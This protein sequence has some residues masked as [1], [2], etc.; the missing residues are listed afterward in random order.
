MA[1]LIFWLLAT[2]HFA[3]AQVTPIPPF[4]GDHSETWEEFGTGLLG[5][6]VP[7]LGGFATIS[8][9][10]LTTGKSFIM[11]TVVAKPS[12]GDTLMY[13]DRVAGPCTI[14]FSQPVS[15]FGAYWGD[16]YRCPKCCD[17]GDAPIVLTF[18]D[19]NGN[20]VGSD[21]FEYTGDGTL[22]WH[23]YQFS[24]PV[25]TIIRTAG[26]GAEG[27]AFDGLQANVASTG[28][29]SLS[30]IS[31]RS[32]VQT[33]DDVLIGGLIIGGSGTKN[34][35]LRALGPTLGQ[36]PFNL[37][38]AMADPT[39]DLFQGNNLIAS[40]D[41][42]RQSANQ[43]A[44]SATGLQPPNDAESAIL[45]SL[46]PGAY[47]AIVRGT[48]NTTGNALFEAY[49]LGGGSATFSNISTR[50][51]VQ[52]SND[53]M[54]A[55]V[56]VQ[57]ASANLLLRALGPTLSDAPFNLANSLAD[58]FLD[59]RDAN[60]AQ[61]ET[62]DNWKNVQQPQIQATGLAPSH[63]SEAAILITLSPGNYTAIVTGVNGTTG[64]AL[65]EVYKLN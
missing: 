32:L 52:T 3:E 17:F 22:S 51:F 30:N 43:A 58:P 29:G 64:N 46:N 48:N 47:T 7:I 62:N 10:D 63:D 34:V 4:A 44:V 25:K 11:C 31:T 50:G 60:G 5:D 6:D 53:I 49:D 16:G 57:N 21:I 41:N 54:I 23:G 13:S 18:K 26:D 20:I 35:L 55:G 45:L 1:A 36:V 33:G 38:N 24:V 2:V 19:G 28:Q 12:D 37:P 40:N 9:T 42:W 65:V 39:L 15:A 8:G 27:F 61:I 56:A 14:T 59:L